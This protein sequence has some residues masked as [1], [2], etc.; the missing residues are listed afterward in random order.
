MI[1]EFDSLEKLQTF[2]AVPSSVLQA[3]SESMRHDTSDFYYD[4]A[5]T[6]Q[7]L[8]KGRTILAEGPMLT[9]NNRSN[10][11]IALLHGVTEHLPDLNLTINGHDAPWVVLGGDMEEIYMA[12]AKRGVC[13]LFPQLLNPDKVLKLLACLRYQRSNIHERLGW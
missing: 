11:M 5:F 3:R 8:D 13:E 10:D 9:R 1:D 6:L 12:A 7:I 2:L 4:K